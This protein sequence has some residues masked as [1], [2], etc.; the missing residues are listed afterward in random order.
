MSIQLRLRREIASFL[1]TFTG[2]GGEAL[3]DTTN[4]RIQVHD[5]STP[6]G[7]P[8]AKLAEVLPVTQQSAYGANVQ[9]QWIEQV[10]TCSGATTNIPLGVTGVME[11]VALRVLTAVTGCSSITV[12]DSQN[13]NGHWGSGIGISAG[14]TNA[15][16]ASPGPY[17]NGS[18]TLALA[19]VGGGASFTGGTV[20]VSV[21]MKIITPPT[22]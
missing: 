9:Y 16:A 3:I 17:Y 2:A 21:L 10:I 8:A 11:C 18:T 6:G 20:R 15:G 4:N 19:A 5:G 13:G 12:N 7:F 14:T 1:A 22:S